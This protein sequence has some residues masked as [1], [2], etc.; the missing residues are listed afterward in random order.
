MTTVDGSKS[1]GGFEKFG[2]DAQWFREKLEEKGV[3]LRPG[4]PMD[5]ALKA[6]TK[7]AVAVKVTTNPS[8][9]AE[10]SCGT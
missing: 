7:I 6:M 1:G 2:G 9:P 8:E 3:K 10:S 4:S 5:A